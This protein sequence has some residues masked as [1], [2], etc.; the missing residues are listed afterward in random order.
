VSLV[1]KFKAIRTGSIV[2]FFLESLQKI[3][4][5]V[6]ASVEKDAHLNIGDIENDH[7]N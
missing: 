6:I 1:T 5:L 2:I 3:S 4:S 7:I